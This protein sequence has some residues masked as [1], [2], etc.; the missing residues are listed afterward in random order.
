MT[1]NEYH[2]AAMRTM[3][4]KLNDRDMLCDGLLAWLVNRA[5]LQI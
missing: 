1:A 3:N 5:K 4:P 2:T